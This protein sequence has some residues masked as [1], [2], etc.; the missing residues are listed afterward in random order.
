MR[1]LLSLPFAVVVLAAGLWTSTSGPTPAIHTISAD[2]AVLSMAAS[3]GFGAVVQLLEW[4]QVEPAPD[5]WYWEYAD[6]LV[7][8]CEHYRMDLVLRLDHP[9]EWAVRTGHS[10]PVDVDAYSH[11]LERVS[12][13]YRGQVF[14]Y[15]IWNEPNLSLEWNGQEP[16]PEGYRV[17]LEAGTQAVRRGDP[18]ALVVAAGPAPTNQNDHQAMSDLD[19]LQA[20]YEPERLPTWD[21]QA[22]HPYGFAQSP[23]AAA[24]DHHGLVFAR[25]DTWARLLDRQGVGHLPLWVTEYGWTVGPTEAA[26]AWQVV[27]PEVQAEYL[28]ASLRTAARAYPRVTFLTVWNLAPGLAPDDPMGGYSLV[29]PDGAAR[30]ALASVGEQSSLRWSRLSRALKTAVGRLLGDTRTVKVLAPDVVIRLSDVDTAYPHWAKPHGGSA[31]TRVWETTFY[32]E[33][34][35]TGSWRLVLETMQVEE[36]S[37]QVYI[38]DRMLLPAIPITGRTPFASAWTT[39]YLE[40]PAGSLRPGANSLRVE[41]SPRLRTQQD[42]RYESL[43]IRNVRLVRP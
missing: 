36:C 8:A 5:E 1:R 18:A 42:I 33:S 28:S 6:W 22:V 2:D 16:D 35:G 34:P 11:F 7:R 25:L 24:K 20:L 13:R 15:I 19:F 12:A 37:N 39:T 32:V 31:P 4:R 10:P 27:S 41:L 30:P 26:D 9:P 17:L 29:A 38:N 23:N 14:A 40:V 43:Q 3:T 21:A